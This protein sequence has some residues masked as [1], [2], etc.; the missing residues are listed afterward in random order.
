MRAG[1]FGYTVST[2]LNTKM[3]LLKIAVN[4]IRTESYSERDKKGAK[5][6]ERKIGAKI[7]EGILCKTSTALPSQN[8]GKALCLNEHFEAVLRKRHRQGWCQD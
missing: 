4:V 5:R 1:L 8:A 2:T 3:L 6:L 7:G